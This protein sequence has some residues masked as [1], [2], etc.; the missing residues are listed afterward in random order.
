M[1]RFTFLLAAVLAAPAALAADW[2]MFRGPKRDNLSPDTGL[3]K[4]WPK[5]GPTLLWTGT[6]VGAGFSSVSVAAGKVFTMGTEGSKTYL[7]AL[8]AD[9][10]TSLWRAEVG[11]GG[12]E[13]YTGSRCT[14]TYDD[15]L[16]YGIGSAGDLVCVS[17]DKGEERWRKNFRKDYGG[18][19]GGWQY[20]ESPLIDGDR[21]L[22]TPG[23]KDATVVCL[24]K[25]T[26]EE[27]WRSAAGGQA[28]YA[29]IVISTA[30]GVK[31]Y[32]TLIAGGTVGIDAQD[33]KLLWKYDKFAGNT[34]NIPTPIP[35]GDQLFTLAG[36]GRSAS[37]LSLSAADGKVTVKEEWTKNNLRNK[38]GG[39][40]VVGD[41]V[42][43]DTDDSG[44]PY[45]AE[46][47]TGETKWVAGKKSGSGSAALTYADGSLYVRYDN[48]TMVLVPA[49]A[50]GYEE[51][52]SFKIPGKKGPPSWAH[53]VVIG[54]KLY[55]RE[56]EQVHCYDVKAK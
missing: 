27:I 19:S 38:H 42:F 10:G 56:A 18:S 43:A 45:C 4:Q 1:Y 52:G 22:C 40:V 53:P 17:A 12:R 5:A 6:G 3:L 15:G 39:A 7:Y 2:P 29:S 24:N 37:L 49:A 8:D 55:L 20:S 47:K 16:L 36:Y 26:G 35:L 48:G 44:R 46:W 32:V 28:G 41:L 33:G 30:A 23:G 11:A 9:K 31:Q 51:K 34:A 21:L 13:S 14:P 25:K 54:G 50:S